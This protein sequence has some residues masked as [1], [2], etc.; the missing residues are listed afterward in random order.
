MEGKRRFGGPPS[1]PNPPSK[2]F[3]PSEEEEELDEDVFLEETL[4]R[5][6]ELLQDSGVEGLASR[7]SKWK[8]PPL[9][10][11]YTTSASQS[12]EFQQLDI[13]YIIGESHREILPH[14]TGQAAIL[15]IFGVTQ[16]GYS[17]CCLVHGFQPY[18]Y[19]SCLDGMGPDDITRFQQVLEARMQEANRNSKVTKFI[20]RIEIVQKRSIMYSRKGHH[21]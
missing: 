6:E 9:P 11:A 5:D 3:Q 13:D 19:I 20:T 4:L 1:A 17:V 2:R 18:F 14:S 16:E 12:I 15:R 10:S 7:L 8:R 21:N